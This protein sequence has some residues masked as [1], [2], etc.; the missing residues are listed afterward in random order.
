M[1]QRRKNKM[2]IM[3]LLGFLFLMTVGYAAFQTNLKIKGTSSISS[4]WDIRITNVTEGNKTGDAESAKAPTWDKLTANVEANLYQ[5]GDSIEYIITVENKG[6]IDAFLS[7]I[8]TNETKHEAIK[9]TV[10]GPNSND[11]LFKGE[12][13][14]IKVKIEYNPEFNGVPEVGSSELNITL[15]YVQAVV[16]GNEILNPNLYVSSTGND[17]TGV[18]STTN[19]YK[20]LQK[21]YEEAGSEATIYIM[22]DITQT[23]T[24]NLNENKN[25]TL[26]SYGVNQPYSVKKEKDYGTYMFIVQKGQLTLDN[27]IIDGENLDSKYGLIDLLGGVKLVTQN[28]TTLKN[29]VSSIRCGGAI[30][31]R[32]NE[33]VTIEI[34]NTTIDNNSS[35]CSG[36][37]HLGTSTNTVINSGTISNNKTLTDAG[38]GIGNFGQLTINNANI[39]GNN[40]KKTGGGIYNAGTTTF[41]GGTIQQNKANNGAGIMVNTVN[42]S[43][44]TL[45]IN[46]GQILNNTSTSTGGGIYSSDNTTINIISGKISGNKS[47]NNNGGGIHSG[48]IVNMSGGEISGNSTNHQGGGITHCSHKLFTMTGGIIANNTSPGAGAGVHLIGPFILDG[49]TIKNNTSTSTTAGGG[50]S[51]NQYLDYNGSYTYKSGIVCEN[52]PT[53]IFETATTCPN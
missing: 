19:P 41:K 39:T 37:M 38:G 6:T 36:A 18:G 48:G 24:F 45:T 47:E 52:V 51:R 33:N 40:A 44:P 17:K 11:K 16:A 34:N 20:T 29:A 28:N 7:N 25:I 3:S 30:S 26:T 46:G 10:E 9:F 27:I 35:L 32:D 13:T 50:I 31:A 42:G 1:R 23:E 53:N 43:N 12:S 49:G 4:N 5:K 21:A 8:T 2:I 15:D 22:D 14:R